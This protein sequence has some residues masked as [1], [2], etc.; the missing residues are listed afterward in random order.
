MPFPSFNHYF[1]YAFWV[2]LPCCLYKSAFEFVTIR[3]KTNYLALFIVAIPINV[4]WVLEF[5]ARWMKLVISTRHPGNYQDQL[6]MWLQHSGII[7]C[8]T[9]LDKKCYGITKS[10]NFLKNTWPFISRNPRITIVHTRLISDLLNKT[11]VCLP[12]KWKIF[13]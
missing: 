6:I 12:E 11:D 7:F 1:L 2:L 10:R 4:F 13:F 8:S 9:S 5:S 3:H